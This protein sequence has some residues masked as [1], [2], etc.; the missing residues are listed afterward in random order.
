MAARS[1]RIPA[2]NR[3]FVPILVALL[4]SCTGAV[5]QWQQA[6]S[7]SGPTNRWAHC[8]AFYGEPGLLRHGLR[9]CS[10]S[11]RDGRWH[12]HQPERDPLR[13]LGVERFGLARSRR[14]QPPRAR[15]RLEHDLRRAQAGC[16]VVQRTDHTVWEFDGVGWT[17]V[18]QSPPIGA[19]HF[20]WMPIECDPV[21]QVSVARHT[22]VPMLR[23]RGGRCVADGD[24]RR[25]RDGADGGLVDLRQ[26]GA[27]TGHSRATC[28]FFPLP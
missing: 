16:R 27:P 20:S 2:S 7:Q 11:R 28:A 14:G 13:H 5:A 21:R 24:C 23:I 25:P 9:R 17:D 18:Q 15:V 12:Q 19:T 26:A 3:R 1:R 22:M 10:R 8:L 4:L 6:P